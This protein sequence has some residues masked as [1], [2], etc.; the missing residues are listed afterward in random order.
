MC[1]P[2]LDLRP[3]FAHPP[4]FALGL[5]FALLTIGCAATKAAP[6]TPAQAPGSCRCTPA[7]PCWPSAAAWQRFGAKLHGRLEQPRPPD[8]SAKTP[9]ALQDQSGGTQSTGWLD[10]WTATPSAQAV[11][12]KDA[13][14]IAAAVTFA[15]E[16]NLRLVVKGTG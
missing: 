7:P 9:S 4:S 16:R 1:M 8:R 10:A 3:S 5:S 13:S 14:D 11:V 12:A 2:S 6:A 15:R